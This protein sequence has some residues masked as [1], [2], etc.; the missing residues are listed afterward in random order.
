MNPLKKNGRHLEA[1]IEC[2]WYDIEEL[3]VEIRLDDS[4]LSYEK[5]NALGDIGVPLD[6]LVLGSFR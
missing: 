5:K 6:L 1:N 3:M 2:Q 4:F